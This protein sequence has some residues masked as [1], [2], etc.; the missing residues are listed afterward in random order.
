ML[1]GL[2]GVPRGIML[3]NDPARRRS[4]RLWCV[5]VSSQQPD[6]PDSAE[7][8]SIQSCVRLGGA[9]EGVKL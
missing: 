4:V 9:L 5:L 8:Q 3:M 6:W 1:P 2:G 7:S